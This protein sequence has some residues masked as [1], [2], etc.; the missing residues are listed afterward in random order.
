MLKINYV[1]HTGIKVSDTLVYVNNVTIDNSRKNMQ[2][3][4]NYMLARA[5]DGFYSPFCCKQ[6]YA[7]YDP[8]LAESPARQFYNHLKTLPEFEHATDMIL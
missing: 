6:F 5:D 7:P 1:M 4:V 3:D 2:S 8:S